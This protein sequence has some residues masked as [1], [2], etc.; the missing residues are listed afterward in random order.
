MSTIISPSLIDHLIGHRSAF[1]AIT[2]DFARCPTG[3]YQNNDYNYEKKN[4]KGGIVGP[5]LLTFENDDKFFVTR[6]ILPAGTLLF[7]AMGQPNGNDNSGASID[8]AG[9]TNAASALR[10]MTRKCV[11]N[12]RGPRYYGNISTSGSLYLGDGAGC[13]GPE[14]SVQMTNKLYMVQMD[15]FAML[16]Y[17][18][19]TRYLTEKV[20][21]VIYDREKM[22]T[23]WNNHNYIS[24]QGYKDP[25]GMQIN[26]LWFLRTKEGRFLTRPIASSTSYDSNYE[27][28]GVLGNTVECNE[29]NVDGTDF[30]KPST[31][32]NSR[33][34][35]N[36]LGST[37]ISSEWLLGYIAFI[38]SYSCVLPVTDLR[39]LIDYYNFLVRE[40]NQREA[41]NG[42]PISHNGH[43]WVQGGGGNFQPQRDYQGNMYES[44]VPFDTSLPPKYRGGGEEQIF[45]KSYCP[46]KLVH[47]FGYRMSVMHIDDNAMTWLQPMMQSLNIDGYYAEEKTV[48]WHSLDQGDFHSECCIFDPGAQ[49][50]HHFISGNKI[51]RGRY[52]INTKNTGDR[53]DRA[54]IGGQIFN[55]QPIDAKG[56]VVVTDR[57][58]ADASTATV[59]TN[60]LCAYGIGRGLAFTNGSGRIK[61][62]TTFQGGWGNIQHMWHVLNG[63]NGVFLTDPQS[64][65][66][67]NVITWKAWCRN[68]SGNRLEI[69][70]YIR[71]YYRNQKTL[72]GNPLDNWRDGVANK[73]LVL[74]TI[75][76]NNLP[77]SNTD[78]DTAG[79]DVIVRKV[80]GLKGGDGDIKT[81]SS[82]T[83]TATETVDTS[84]TIENV[85]RKIQEKEGIP[86][87]QQRLTFEG[88]NT[89]PNNSMSD[90]DIPSFGSS[91]A[92]QE[93]LDAIKSV[94]QTSPLQR[95]QM[96]VES[97]KR[98]SDHALNLENFK[99][100]E[101]Y[102]DFLSYATDFLKGVMII[103]CTQED[104]DNYSNTDDVENDITPTVLSPEVLREKRMKRFSP[105]NKGGKRKK[106]KYTRK[107]RRNNKSRKNKNN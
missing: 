3:L 38:I 2:E 63:V 74:N 101:F 75:D 95:Q 97:E 7:R 69:H 103:D 52:A 77:G 10:R 5:K 37:Y 92:T 18:C 68:S 88:K 23:G 29:N 83:Q 67:I 13:G 82:T 64:G 27:A 66:S 58:S 21:R 11:K 65:T 96:S 79:S 30:S 8:V 4:R 98:D 85:K 54:P 47:T 71:G 55:P 33:N 90:N 86:K 56:H 40:C 84:D 76:F 6:R 1:G 72:N 100:D 46:P 106:K 49:P 25:G 73:R 36:Y 34:N 32:L 99:N 31:S 9:A 39:E 24:S 20:R 81:L 87:D 48:P 14:L 51:N 44:Y 107:K 80:K 91:K 45:F 78:I 57:D 104:L 43:E 12:T 16:V 60:I 53:V 70:N 17:K 42:Q 35:S 94:S 59:S 62:D 89:N 61:T 15:A 19:A 105:K 102:Q 50:R 26:P 28:Y 41:S 93:E 22:T